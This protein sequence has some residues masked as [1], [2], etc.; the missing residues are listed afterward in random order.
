MLSPFKNNHFST[1]TENENYM[2]KLLE[3]ASESYYICYI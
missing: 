1:Y 3:I 2:A